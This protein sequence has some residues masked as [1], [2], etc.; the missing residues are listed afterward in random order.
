MFA[1][2][3]TLQ[4]PKKQNRQ[5]LGCSTVLT[6]LNKTSRRD[7]YLMNHLSKSAKLIFEFGFI[8]RDGKG[9]ITTVKDLER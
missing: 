2:T 5:F 7:V 6:W 9:R 8:K 3:S 4:R 1:N